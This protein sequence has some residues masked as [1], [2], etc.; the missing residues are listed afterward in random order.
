[1]MRIGLIEQELVRYDENRLGTKKIG[2]AQPLNT[3]STH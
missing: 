3:K 2:P 1:M